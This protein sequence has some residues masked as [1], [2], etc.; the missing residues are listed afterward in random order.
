[1]QQALRAGIAHRTLTQNQHTA[2]AQRA[3]IQSRHTE[4]AHR[5]STQR[6]HTE[7][8]HRAS[9][10]SHHCVLTFWLA[11][12]P[13]SFPGLV[14]VCLCGA[15]DCGVP[16]VYRRYALYNLGQ[17]FVL[18]MQGIVEQIGT[19]RG[20]F[21][22]KAL[23]EGAVVSEVRG[24]QVTETPLVGKQEKGKKWLLEVAVTEVEGITVA[25]SSPVGKS[26]NKK[27][28]DEVIAGGEGGC[29]G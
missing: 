22:H 7:P 11:A 17:N 1:M 15:R 23:L 25:E 6:R 14:W 28:N 27:R 8:A 2:P 20:S 10:Q 29:Q 9:T 12:E 21:T 5:V 13:R 16:V 26:E 19:P 18:A 4:P 24:M 3:S